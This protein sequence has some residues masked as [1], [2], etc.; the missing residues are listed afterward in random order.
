MSILQISVDKIVVVHGY[1]IFRMLLTRVMWNVDIL[2]QLS[3]L[4]FDKSKVVLMRKYVVSTIFS[5]INWR[6]HIRNLPDFL[7]R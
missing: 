3:S 1:H 6:A 7:L 4:W 5:R 2:R